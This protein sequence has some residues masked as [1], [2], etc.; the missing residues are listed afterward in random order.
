MWERQ[1]AM[2]GPGMAGRN[3]EHNHT[4]SNGTCHKRSVRPD[5]VPR[6]EPKARRGLRASSGGFG[7]R[8]ADSLHA[9]QNVNNLHNGVIVLIWAQW[10]PSHKEP[11]SSAPE[12][13]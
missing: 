7:H 8:T 4:T 3:A 9:Q 12:W 1:L 5:A 11:W 6:T 13:R 10:F 2:L